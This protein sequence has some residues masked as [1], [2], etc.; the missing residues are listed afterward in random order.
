MGLLETPRP[1]VNLEMIDPDV[2]PERVLS[3]E[4]ES[5]GSLLVA[6]YGSGNRVTVQRNNSNFTLTVQA[7]AAGELP[8]LVDPAE[9]REAI[10]LYAEELGL[11]PEKVTVTTEVDL[12]WPR[13][14]TQ[15]AAI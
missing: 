9:L 15:A 14:V 10:M 13:Y 5:R 3:L 4:T 6:D 7:N 8:A 11:D 2:R 1:A 12:D